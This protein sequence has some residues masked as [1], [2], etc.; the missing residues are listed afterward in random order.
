MILYTIGIKLLYVFIKCHSLFNLKSK[1]WIDGRKNWKRNLQQLVAQQNLQNAIWFHCASLG[2]FEQGR[3]VLELIK[4]QHANKKILLT[5]FSP[6]G[7]LQLID[8]YKTV[9]AIF[10]IPLDTK[11]NAQFFLKTLK[12]T[13]VINVKYE[14]WLH[15]L[16]EIKKQQIPSYLISS[17]F[18]THQPFFKWYGSIF[19]NGLQTYT[20]IFTQ[21]E[22]SLKLLNS[23]DIKNAT[24]T[25]D[26][27]IDRV[28]EIKE[29][30]KPDLRIESFLRNNFTIIAG[31]TWPKDELKLIATFKSLKNSHPQIKLIIAP[32]EVNTA[33][34]AYIQKLIEHNRLTYQVYSNKNDLRLSN[35]IMIIDCIGI[36]SNLYQYG[37]IT[38]I[39]GGFDNGIHNILEPS[40]FGL[41]VIFGPNYK[42]FN[43][44]V[45][46]ISLKTAYCINSETELMAIIKKYLS[47]SD[48]LEKTSN[49]LMYYMQKQVGVSSKVLDII[50]FGFKLQV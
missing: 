26:T 6:S 3:P 1:Q 22:A 46:L 10:Y 25:G 42:K 12:P 38:Y 5:F 47:H 35:D 9:D 48:E 41:S 43:E 28:F 31:S 33:H 11:H 4:K 14:F 27:R 37:S 39:G 44:A 32:H 50:S 7:Y 13:C 49:A 40:V 8:K 2:E 20:H 17:V 16:F 34:I 23:I 24:F 18:K 29:N 30:K 21:D 19:K 45:Q 36:L 15:F